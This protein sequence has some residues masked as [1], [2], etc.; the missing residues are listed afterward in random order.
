MKKNRYKKAKL[1]NLEKNLSLLGKS[2]FSGLI[3]FK[4][5]CGKIFS[6]V[7]K[8]IKEYEKNSVG[9]E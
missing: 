9:K 4:D 6:S 3:I 5:S 2:I 1:S 8:I 7:C